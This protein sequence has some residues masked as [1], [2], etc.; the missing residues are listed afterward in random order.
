MKQKHAN[1]VALIVAF[2]GVALFAVT[3]VLAFA[4]TPIYWSIISGTGGVLLMCLA[5]MVSPARG[6]PASTPIDDPDKI[7]VVPSGGHESHKG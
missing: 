2:G 1:L 3:Y 6:L 4:S 5:G 7:L